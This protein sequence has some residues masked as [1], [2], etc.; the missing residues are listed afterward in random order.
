L[1]FIYFPPPPAITP[2]MMMM[3]LFAAAHTPMPLA[4]DADCHDLRHFHCR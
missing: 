2:L 3:I 4:A 1:L